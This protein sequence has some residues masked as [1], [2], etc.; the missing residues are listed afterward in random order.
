[1]FFSAIAYFESDFKPTS[2]Y[3]EN[4]R[5]SKGEPVVS[6]GLLQLS[7]GD[8]PR[9]DCNFRTEADTYDVQKNLECGVKICAKL[10]SKDG[11][12]ASGSGEASSPARGCARY[13]STIREGAKHHREEIMKA[14]W[15]TC[16]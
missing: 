12:L 6:A 11:V 16:K 15:S 1:M 9:Y 3:V 4:F 14:A 13:W 7:V 10:A 8:S 2:R 5:D